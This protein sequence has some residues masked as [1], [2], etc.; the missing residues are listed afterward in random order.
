[1]EQNSKTDCKTAAVPRKAVSSGNR[2]AMI[3]TNSVVGDLSVDPY[4]IIK[5]V[6]NGFDLFVKSYHS[7]C[8]P[9][10]CRCNCHCDNMMG[11]N[12]DCQGNNGDYNHI[13]NVIGPIVDKIEGYL[14]EGK[15]ES[16]SN[17]AL[18]G[19]ALVRGFGTQLN[20]IQYEDVNNTEIRTKQLTQIYLNHEDHFLKNGKELCWRLAILLVRDDIYMEVRTMIG[21]F[22]QQYLQDYH[23]VLKS[24]II[25]LHYAANDKSNGISDKYKIQSLIVAARCCEFQRKN[26]IEGLKTYWLSSEVPCSLDDFLR[27]KRGFHELMT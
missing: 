16:P 2:K 6:A 4:E 21:N 12:C 27:A 3:S 19:E 1:L 13:K 17:A 9:H 23:S 20:A 8:N 11:D 15:L 24:Y 22:L 26:D 7:A 25:Q 18:V 5:S 10:N 14:Q